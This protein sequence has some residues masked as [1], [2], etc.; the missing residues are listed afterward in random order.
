MNEPT[1][2]EL[3]ELLTEVLEN[4]KKFDEK[5]DKV[6]KSTTENAREIKSL[7]SENEE[8][9]KTN[10]DL[11]KNM[12][13]IRKKV[14]NQ[15]LK[16][17]AKNVILHNI[18]DSNEFNKDLFNKVLEITCEIGVYEQ[19]IDSIKR[20]GIKEGRR[21]VFITVTSLASKKIF[22]DN[23]LFLKSK[24]II[25]TN[26]TTKKEREDYKKLKEIKE[27]LANF[28]SKALIKNSKLFVEDH[29][30]D[31]PQAQ[32]YVD[33]L[34]KEIDDK[35]N[36]D[37]QNIVKQ[38]GNTFKTPAKKRGRESISP[39]VNTN[40]LKKIKDTNKNN[41]KNNDGDILESDNE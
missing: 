20:I 29:C 32:K 5:I 9:K 21:P 16:S 27:K 35:I 3:K 41:D 36:R 40:S 6:E 33:E 25:V 26:D 24:G 2:S 11:I 12:D 15:N 4:V 10:K 34:E 39:Q 38:G 28:G 37:S 7:K 17:R 23:L 22:F 1:N 31:I 14:I 18:K 19:H 8:L 30:F 13:V